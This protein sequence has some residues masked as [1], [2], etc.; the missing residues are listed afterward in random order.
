MWR[1]IA[2][3]GVVGSAI[4][5]VLAAD[6]RDSI[7]L[8]LTALP[9]ISIFILRIVSQKREIKNSELFCY[10]LFL[11]YVTVVNLVWCLIEIYFS[12]DIFK[13]MSRRVFFQYVLPAGVVQI[14]KPQISKRFND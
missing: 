5:M 3:Y 9:Y 7:E 2:L 12:T 11:G 6:G 13:E 10:V 1:L 8:V 14:A 4:M